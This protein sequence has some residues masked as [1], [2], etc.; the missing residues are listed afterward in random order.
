MKTY[1]VSS[2]YNRL[3]KHVCMLL[4][5]VC[6]RVCAVGDVVSVANW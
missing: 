4:V 1:V 2:H 5:H 6:M 3:D